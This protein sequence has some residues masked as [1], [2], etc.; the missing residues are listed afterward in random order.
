M[1]KGSAIGKVILNI[2]SE[3]I[4]RRQPFLSEVSAPH[5]DL[6]FVRHAESIF[7]LACENY[8]KKHNIPYIW[9][10]LCNH[11]GFDTSVLYNPDFI[12][13]S[14]TEFGKL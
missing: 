14:I 4:A 2:S 5:H 3:A 7:N 13:C 10:E 12:D 8:R 6:V 1:L 9:K 11:E